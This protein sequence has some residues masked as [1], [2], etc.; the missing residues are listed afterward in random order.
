[1]N[2]VDGLHGRM[3]APRTS[4]TP[5]PRSRRTPMLCGPGLDGGGNGGPRPLSLSGTQEIS[6][7]AATCCRT[8]LGRP[9]HCQGVSI[10]A[11]SDYRIHYV[12]V[13]LGLESL[14]HAQPYWD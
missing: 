11:A 6:A 4:A 1:M 2:S 9:A 10:P 13:A 14:T 3:L 12:T 7:F 8:S 5:L